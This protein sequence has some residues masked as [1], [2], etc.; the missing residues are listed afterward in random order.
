MTSTI[1]WTTKTWNPVTGCTKI[2]A[3]C[4]LCYADFRHNIRH[5]AYQEGKLQTCPQYA[6]PFSEI[7]FI[8]SRLTVPRH[9]RKG[10][11]VFVN[12]VSDLFH[13]GVSNSQIQSVLDVCA[14]TPRH[15][16]QILTKRPERLADFSYP[17]NVWLGVTVENQD[18]ADKRIPLLKGV[19]AKIR[20]LSCEP[21][22]EPLRLDLDGVHWVIAG[23]E[24]GKGA[25]FMKPD[26]ARDIQAQCRQ[27]GV[28]FFMKQMTK[29][30]PIPDDLMIR[31]YPEETTP[32]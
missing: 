6:R 16:F 2:S 14:Q 1:E 15:S 5:K 32:I 27:A 7:Q 20:F 17:D 12:S 23:G 29:K 11:R 4:K 3:G 22:L 31:E 21:L 8:E 30:A 19:R 28:A 24:T 9:W 18:A 13:E 10:R 26:W 25:R